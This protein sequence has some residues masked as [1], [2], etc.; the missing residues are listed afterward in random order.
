MKSHI[1][2]GKARLAMARALETTEECALALRSDTPAPIPALPRKRVIEA[3]L[4]RVCAVHGRGYISRY[5]S[6]AK[7]CFH[8]AQS[9][10]FKEHLGGQ[11]ED[12]NVAKVPNSQLADET[13]PWCGAVGFGSINCGTC[14]MEICYGRTTAAGQF[15]CRDACTGSGRLAPERRDMQGYVPGL[16][17]PGAVG[18]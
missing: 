16:R 1:V 10:R 9:F 8:Y 14:R 13:C 17:P 7:G 6:D 11:Y 12:S 18:T 3:D 5:V 15:T 4:P 2:A